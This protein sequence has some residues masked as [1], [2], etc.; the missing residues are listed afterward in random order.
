MNCR[1]GVIWIFGLPCAGKTTIADALRDELARH[2]I[3]ALRLDGDQLRK[4]LCADL[5][6][7]LEDR[8]ENIRRAAHMARLAR[9]AGIPT[10]ASLITPTEALRRLAAEIIGQ[11]HFLPVFIDCPASEC[12]RRDVKGLYAQAR[13]GQLTGLTGAGGAFETPEDGGLTV[14]S[15]S[16]SADEIVATIMRELAVRGWTSAL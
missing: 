1:S 6:S 8:T 9:A 7:S 5:G 15:D 12:A 4:G 14:H 3:T 10:I 2:A 11:D 13:A 16:Q